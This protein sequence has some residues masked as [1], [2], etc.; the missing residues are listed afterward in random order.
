MNDVDKQGHF[1]GPYD[2]GP[3]EV[4]YLP[5]NRRVDHVVGIA[6][7]SHDGTDVV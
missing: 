4:S 5:G 1:F 6:I 7:F 2:G 3:A